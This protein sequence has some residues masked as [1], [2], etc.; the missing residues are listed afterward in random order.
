MLGILHYIKNDKVCESGEVILMDVGAEYANYNGDLTRCV[1]VDGKFTKRQKEV[2]NAVKFVLEEA[3]KLLKPGNDFKSYNRDVVKLMEEKL[4]ELN[5]ITS[6][7]V[8]NQNEKEPVYKKYFMHGISHFLGLDV[9]DVGKREGKFKPGMVLTCEPG[10]YIR[11]EGLG[12]RLEND[13]LIGTNGHIDL[14]GDIP[15]ETDEIE[16]IMNS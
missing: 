13:V 6:D 14:M 3:K 1:P 5:L 16:S 4:I 2:Y 12:I 10:I 9:H 7:E 15:I 8:R 11:E